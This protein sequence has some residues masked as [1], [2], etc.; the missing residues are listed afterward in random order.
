M[1]QS[2]KRSKPKAKLTDK[3]QFARFV[4]TARELEVDE[5]SESF[6]KAVNSVL[7]VKDAPRPTLKKE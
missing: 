2:P 3:E 6:S 7:K 4:K 5:S 1:K